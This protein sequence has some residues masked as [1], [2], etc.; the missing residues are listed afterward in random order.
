MCINL[1]EYSHNHDSR[2]DKLAF[3]L[4]FPARPSGLFSSL[5][6]NMATM[7]LVIQEY[8]TYKYVIAITSML[9][10]FSLRG[11]VNENKVGKQI[12]KQTRLFASI[13]LRA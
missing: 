4:K 11:F 9:D 13:F 8:F 3:N 2:E 6:G 10:N 1:V 12:G 5:I 7:C